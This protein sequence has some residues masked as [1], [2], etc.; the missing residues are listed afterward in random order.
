MFDLSTTERRFARK[1]SRTRQ[2]RDEE[3]GEA[4][5]GKLDRPRAAEGRQT[6][7]YAYTHSSPRKETYPPPSRPWRH[8]H[9]HAC[10]CVCIAP[11]CS[12]SRASL[13]RV[14]AFRTPT[15]ASRSTRS[16]CRPRLPRAAPSGSISDEPDGRPTP[17]AGGTNPGGGALIAEGATRAWRMCAREE[18]ISMWMF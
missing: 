6:Y 17:S 18:R 9:D 8:A 5:E 15:H 2:K 14:S 13:M 4:D 3:A 10:D 16:S 11:A 12:R 7:L 1:W